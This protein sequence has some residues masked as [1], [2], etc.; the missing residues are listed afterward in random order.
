M[1]HAELRIPL[2][3]EVIYFKAPLFFV[4]ENV[5]DLFKIATVGAMRSEVFYEFEGMFILDDFLV[6]LGFADEV[7]VGH[8]PLVRG[9]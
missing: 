7:G 1:I 2:T 4:F 3:V 8:V 6:E 9:G 5:Y